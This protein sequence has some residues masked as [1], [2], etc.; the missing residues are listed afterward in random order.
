MK[1]FIDVSSS[2]SGT[3]VNDRPGHAKPV[4]EHAEAGRVKSLFHR[5]ENLTAVGKQLVNL[6]RL[7]RGIDRKIE[8]DAAHLLEGGWRDV[9]SDQLVMP[10]GHPCMD[11]CF[12]RATR[13]TRCL[14]LIHH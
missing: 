7:F 11:D 10:D 5:H 8:V 14:A 3:F 1:A 2:L 9:V 6:L 4:T 12:P 13:C